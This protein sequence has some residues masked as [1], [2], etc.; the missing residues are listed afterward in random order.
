MQY[1]RLGKTELEVSVVSFGGLKLP[2]VEPK[3]ATAALN[4]ALDLGINFIDTARV[5]R[6][7]E[8]KIGNAVKDRRDEFYI[9]T[10]TAARGF[11]DAMKDIETSLKELQFEKIDLFQLHTVSDE[12]TYKKVMSSDGALEAAKKAQAQGK[13]D[14]IGITI[15]RAISVMRKA[16]ESGE[17]ETIMVA[18]SPLD[19]EGVEEEILP[20]AKEHDVGV[21]I[22]KPLSGGQLVTP[23][24][25]EE[26]EKADFDPIVRGSLWYI[27]SNDNVSTVIPGMTCVRE[28]EENVQIGDFTEKIP[29]DKKDELFRLIAKLGASFRYGQDC[30]R[31]GY[32]LPCSVDIQI[33]E[34]FRAYDMYTNYPDNLKYLGIELYK[35]LEVSP[36]E[37]IECEECM[38][39]CP[40][41][42]PIPERLKKAVEVFEKL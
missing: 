4:R 13:I 17:F 14:H 41:N 40:G 21:I 42:I 35:S 33:P 7:S 27:T 25:D 22:M 23:R 12:D 30:L 11:E 15:H 18:Y 34:V 6:D 38:E 29:D 24:S 31:C 32:C 2:G 36:E 10:K 5:Y 20:M 26:R 16:I 19:Q 3:S 8:R 9:A 28:V 37:C 39:K 1:R